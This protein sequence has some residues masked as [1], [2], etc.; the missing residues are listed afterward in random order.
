MPIQEW[1]KSEWF[2]LCSIDNF[3]KNEKRSRSGCISSCKAIETQQNSAHRQY[4]NKF[5]SFKK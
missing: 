3:G 2:V 4:G 5:D 1:S